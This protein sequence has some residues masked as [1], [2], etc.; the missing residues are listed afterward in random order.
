MSASAWA[1]RVVD[2]TADLWQETQAGVPALA[3]G[4]AV[5]ASPVPA[6]TRLLFV[7]S[8]PGGGA[9]RFD[10]ATAR[11]FPAEHEYV[12]GS[13]HHAVRMREV[14]AG[15]RRPDLLQESA[16]VHLNFFRVR[17]Q[18]WRKLPPQ[19]RSRLERFCEQSLAEIGERLA[20]AIVLA[21]GM[22]VFDRLCKVFGVQPS[23]RVTGK[24]GAVAGVADLPWGGRLIGMV[25]PSDGK[26]APGDLLRAERA[27]A[28][29][30]AEAGV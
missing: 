12:A 13:H 5:F 25:H 20:P 8:A 17:E 1:Q 30:V 16:K 26:A 21:E 18:D 19:L 2:A 22:P 29:W 9:S 6:S 14:F 23:S 3:A 27:L 7:G 10:A 15:M 4:Y 11:I 24:Q 28:G